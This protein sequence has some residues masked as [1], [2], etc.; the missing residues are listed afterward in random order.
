MAGLAGGCS[1]LRLVSQTLPTSAGFVAEN[2]IETFCVRG[3]TRARGS[4]CE[5][6]IFPSGF[7]DG[8]PDLSESWKRCLLRAWYGAKTSEGNIECA[9][10]HESKLSLVQ[11][12][13]G[14][15]A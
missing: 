4:A 2:T 6:H 11:N 7:S 10:R 5:L 9:S 15:A 14:A 8:G 13:F 3:M 12:L 1:D